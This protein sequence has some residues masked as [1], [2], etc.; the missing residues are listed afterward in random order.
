MSSD[1]DRLLPPTPRPSGVR[2]WLRSKF[3]DI[4]LGRQTQLGSSVETITHL[5]VGILG[6]C[7]IWL[8]ISSIVV[9]ELSTW[10]DAIAI[11]FPFYIWSLIRGYTIRR[12]YTVLFGG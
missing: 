11:N 12:V 7:L 6:S 3:Y 5:V 1:T 8:Y 10:R 4:R 9:P 2:A